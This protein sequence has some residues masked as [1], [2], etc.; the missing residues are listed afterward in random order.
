M[1]VHVDPVDKSSLS[2]KTSR[3]QGTAISVLK[4]DRMEAPG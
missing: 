4:G 1:A 3:A 2:L